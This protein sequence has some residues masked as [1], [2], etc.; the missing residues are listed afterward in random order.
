MWLVVAILLVVFVV[1][2]GVAPQCDGSDGEE[3]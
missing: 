1:V 2:H 3:E